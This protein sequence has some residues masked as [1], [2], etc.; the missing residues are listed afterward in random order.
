MGVRRPWLSALVALLVGILFTGGAMAKTKLFIGLP[1]A[2]GI[3]DPEMVERFT[4]ANPDLD[5]EVLSVAWGDF[6]EKLPAM[7]ATGTAPDVWYGEA[8]RALGWRHDG[9][10][11]DLTRY[12]ERDLDLSDYF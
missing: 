3:H 10:T 7:L 1:G 5:V 11:A 4:A 9:V 8:G 6:F 2:S 12:V